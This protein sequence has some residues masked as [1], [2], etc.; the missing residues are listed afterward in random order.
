[1]LILQ[2]VILWVHFSK[3]TIYLKSYDPHFVSLT[4][5][6]GILGECEKNLV[7]VTCNRLKLYSVIIPSELHLKSGIILYD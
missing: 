2:L 7:A 4:R 6:H 3:V 1:M 5:K